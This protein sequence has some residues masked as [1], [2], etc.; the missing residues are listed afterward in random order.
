MLYPLY[1]ALQCYGDMQIPL[2]DEFDLDA[3]RSV[4]AVSE[5]DLTD[6]DI[7]A[8]RERGY[9]DL[10]SEILLP[11]LTKA[12]NYWDQMLTPDYYTDSNG[13]IHY[14]AGKTELADGEYYC[15]LPSYSPENNPA[16]YP[17][18]ST[19]NCAIDISACSST[20]EMLTDIMKSVDENADTGYWEQIR[21]KPITT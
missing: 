17:S 3:L 8:I 21:C 7:T 9:L 15:I 20:L 16:N 4:L 14:E 10:R 12:A 18:P 5:A 2:S 19:A 1:E 11:L 6:A 13:N